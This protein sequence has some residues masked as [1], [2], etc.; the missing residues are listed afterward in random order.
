MGVGAACPGLKEGLWFTLSVWPG[1]NEGFKIT[2]L[3]RWP[4]SEAP[5]LPRLLPLRATLFRAASGGTPVLLGG[6]PPAPCLP[7]LHHDG[8]RRQSHRRVGRRE[9]SGR[10]EGPFG[11]AETEHPSKQDPAS[12][13]RPTPTTREGLCQARGVGNRQRK[14]TSRAGLGTQTVRSTPQRQRGQL[15]RFGASLASFRTMAVP[16]GDTLEIR[17]PVSLVP[18]APAAGGR[19]QPSVFRHGNGHARCG[20]PARRVSRHLLRH[21]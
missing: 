9:E 17:R 1:G 8:R 13:D 7:L 3:L 5:L 20:P 15:L 11:A 14:C 18:Q 6:S 2:E 12:A 16:H 21:G 19:Q 4:L 10:L